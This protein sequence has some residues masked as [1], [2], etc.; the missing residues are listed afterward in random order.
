PPPPPTSPPSAMDLLRP[1]EPFALYGTRG[2]GQLLFDM[3]IAG[4]FIA[5]FTQGRVDRTKTGTF[6][7]RENRFFPREIELN[8]FGQ[9]DPYARAEVRIDGGEEFAK[10][11]ITI[12]LAEANLTLLTLPWGTQLKMGQ[13]RARFGLLNQIH[14]H[15]LPQADRPNVLRVFLG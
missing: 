8:L 15:D 2:A 4:D 7:G 3:G 1:R 12:R 10:E 6:A 11:D 9:I 13:M 14:E 5:D